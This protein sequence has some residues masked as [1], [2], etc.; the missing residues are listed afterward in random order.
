MA[1]VRNQE[2]EAG[3]RSVRAP[4]LNCLGQW[5]SDEALA[6]AEENSHKDRKQWKPEFNRRKRC[7]QTIADP[8][9]RK[10]APLTAGIAFMGH[11]SLLS[12]ANHVDLPGLESRILLMCTHLLGKMD[13]TKEAY[14]YSILSITPL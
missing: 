13:P 10:V 9:V 8:F 1:V 3:S 11:F 4:N 14:G 7:G 2:I 5:V 6:L 12:L